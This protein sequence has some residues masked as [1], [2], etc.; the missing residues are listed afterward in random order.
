MK[1]KGPVI[2]LIALLGLAIYTSYWQ[3]TNCRVEFTEHGHPI[4]VCGVPDAVLE[5]KGYIHR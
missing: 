5:E 3:A 4:S 2:F 1:A